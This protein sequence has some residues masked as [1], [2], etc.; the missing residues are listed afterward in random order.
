MNVVQPLFE[1]VGILLT[2]GKHFLHRIYFR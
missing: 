2:R 1:K